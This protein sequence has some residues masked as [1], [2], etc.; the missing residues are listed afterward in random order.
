MFLVSFQSCY[1]Y[2]RLLNA[3]PQFSD[4]FLLIDQVTP[5]NVLL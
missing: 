5:L 3:N 2:D 1:V 4:Y